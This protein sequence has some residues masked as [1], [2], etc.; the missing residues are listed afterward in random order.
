MTDILQRGVRYLTDSGLETTL[1]FIDQ[2]KLPSFAAFPLVDTKL[3]RQR[4]ITYYRQHADIAAANWMG[5]VFETPTWRASRDWGATVG[6]G[7][8]AIDRVNREAVRLIREIEA[9][10]LPC[11]PTLVSGNIGPRGDGYAARTAMTVADAADYH[12]AQID[13][14][15][16]A[17]VISAFTMTSAAEAAG[18][19]LAARRRSLPVVVSFTTETDGRL[20]SGQSLRAAIAEVDCATE[21]YAEHFMVNC[22]HP[23]HFA[24]ALDGPFA[25]RIKGI[26]A[27]A[28][29]R[30]HNELDGCAEL[31]IGDIDALAWHYGRLLRRLPQLQ[32]FGGCCGTDLRHIKKMVREVAPVAVPA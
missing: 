21:A 32:V 18:I 11:M 15:A 19:V 4:L 1:V 14:L 25:R 10:Y 13:A 12:E 27:N 16:E 28:S 30:S 20:P 5:F 24:C 3:G 26:R 7:E 2:V 31:D 17:D 23:E 22:A 6:Y 8:W 29:T 9:E